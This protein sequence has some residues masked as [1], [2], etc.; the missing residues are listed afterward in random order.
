MTC[1]PKMTCGLGKRSK[2]PSSIIAWA[3]WAVSSAGWKT[4]STVP[5]QASRASASRAVAPASQVTCMSCPQ[6]CMTGTSLPAGS[7][8]VAMLAYGRLVA[9]LI[10]SASMSARSMTVGPSPLDK[11]PTTPVP[12]TP[13][14]TA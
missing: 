14:V 12:P 4:A 1:W 5:L 11:S 9:S 2:R 10:G 7:V 6:A 8:A 13:V 3:P